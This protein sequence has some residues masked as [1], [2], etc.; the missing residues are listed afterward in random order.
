MAGQYYYGP[1][2]GEGLAAGVKA[3]FDAY[4]KQKERQ[5]IGLKDAMA[6]DEHD[7]RME[8]IEYQ[9]GRRGITEQR[10]D[11]ALKKDQ[12][13]FENSLLAQSNAQMGL[14][15][16]ARNNT[17]QQKQQVHTEAMW[18]SELTEAQ[19]RASKAK[20][21]SEQAMQDLQYQSLGNAVRYIKGGNFK[22]ATTLWNNFHPD[23]PVDRIDPH[24]AMP[25]TVVVRDRDGDVHTYTL[26]QL[27]QLV[28][29]YQTQKVAKTERGQKIQSLM[30]RGHSQQDAEDLADGRVRMTSPDQFGDVYLV[31]ITDGSRRK[32]GSPQGGNQIPGNS[33]SA[34]I[35]EGPV[36]PPPTHLGL[37]LD[38]AAA[39]GTG[40]FA[41]LRQGVNNV[42]GPI[43]T[44]QPFPQTEA[45]RNTLRL[46]GQEVKQSLVNSDRF[47]VHEQRLVE[48]MLPSPDRFLTDPDGEQEKIRQLFN[49]LVEKRAM[50]EETLQG[51]GITAKERGAITNQNAAIS[52]TLR[53]MGPV[54]SPESSTDPRQ[55]HSMPGPSSRHTPKVGAIEEGYIFLGGNPAD[56]SSW[57]RQ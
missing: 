41:A 46:F 49:F 33:R 15:A 30:A 13:D 27:D 43:L 34:T 23:D 19:S 57:R 51:E 5:R 48:R 35:P 7:A 26:D 45:A 54:S 16:G 3:G 1:G 55:S 50:N 18:P 20:A 38:A 6:Q 47:P 32:V 31:N 28:S 14:E 24:P 53:M 11:L 25:G 42:I 2:L 40:P 17:F 36:Q 4:D 21:D 52:R 29:G 56:P 44:G 22:Q 9:K 39:E 8:E 12:V 37:N 10:D